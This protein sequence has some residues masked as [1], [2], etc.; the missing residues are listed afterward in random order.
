M[1]SEE[2]LH[3]FRQLSREERLVLRDALAT[4]DADLATTDA[5]LLSSSGGERRRRRF[6]AAMTLASI[7]LIPWIVVLGLTLPH[8]YVA[9]HWTLTWVGF[10]VLLLASLAATGWF[11]WRRRQIVILAAFTTGT[12][13]LCDAWF[14]VTTASGSTDTLVA[15]ATAV[16]LELPLA[17]L[18]FMTAYHLLHLTVRRLRA[19]QG[20]V[21]TSAALLKLPLFG[22]SAPPRLD[23]APTPSA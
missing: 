1:I 23:D 21:E 10:D 9:G 5:R 14:D 2:L 3:Q 12:L 17:G 15:L 7:G 16:V 18:L 19:A 22:A 11:A 13:L 8:R 6:A 4:I 20:I